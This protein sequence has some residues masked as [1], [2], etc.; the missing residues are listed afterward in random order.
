PAA[1][2]RDRQVV[3]A[4]EPHRG[5]HVCRPGAARDERGPAAVV[6]TVPD[7]RGLDVPVVSRRQDLPA[8]GFTQLLDCCFPEDRGDCLAHGCSPFRLRSGEFY[9][10]SLCADLAARL[11]AA[12]LR[13][14]SSTFETPC[15]S[16]RVSY[17][18]RASARRTD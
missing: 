18:L 6:R 10:A 17:R 9:P 3:A 11:A 12:R 4:R 14:L 16:S 15:A 8:N 7:T 5:D 13:S 1:A 2:Y